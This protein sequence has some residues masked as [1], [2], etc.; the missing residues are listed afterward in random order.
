M[1][2]TTPPAPSP[3]T[4]VKKFGTGKGT[5]IHSGA[6]VESDPASVQ[7]VP[8]PAPVIPVSPVV[9]PLDTPMAL[10]DAGNLPSEPIAPPSSPSET[11]ITPEPARSTAAPSTAKGPRVNAAALGSILHRLENTTG[12][13]ALKIY[14]IPI[15]LDHATHSLIAGQAGYR[16][17]PELMRQVFDEISKSP[18]VTP[19]HLKSAAQAVT[20]AR[21]PEGKG[22]KGPAPKATIPVDDEANKILAVLARR[23]GMAPKGVMEAVAYIYANQ[24]LN[25]AEASSLDR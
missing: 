25:Q 3:T 8:F 7:G 22:G 5:Q 12:T 4:L 19:R 16:G 10:Q 13:P 15:Q 11:P 21:R 14:P 1:S 18:V 20:L 6:V 24:F 2:T 17:I 9:D 23:A